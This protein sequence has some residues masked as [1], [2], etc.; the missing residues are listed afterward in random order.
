MKLNH[1]QATIQEHISPQGMEV[2]LRRK[3]PAYTIYH[4]L[5]IQRNINSF[6]FDSDEYK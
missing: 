1:V 2:T 3:Y 4:N 6:E 5:I